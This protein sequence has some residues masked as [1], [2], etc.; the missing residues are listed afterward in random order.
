ME[1]Q[2]RLRTA[3]VD[4][5]YVRDNEIITGVICVQQLLLILLLLYFISSKLLFDVC[6]NSTASNLNL[7]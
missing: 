5:L 6:K 2:I 3:V 7:L 1:R 4:F